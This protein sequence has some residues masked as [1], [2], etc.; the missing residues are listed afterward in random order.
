LNQQTPARRA[1][2]RLT[3]LGAAV[4]SCLAS[5]AFCLAPSANADVACY[6]DALTQRGFNE[7]VVNSPISQAG[8]TVTPTFTTPPEVDAALPP[9]AAGQVSRTVALVNGVFYVAD[10]ARAAGT[11]AETTNMYTVD[12]AT[13]A[14]TPFATVTDSLTVATGGLVTSV[15]S[16]SAPTTTTTSTV[17]SGPCSGCDVSHAALDAVELAVCN[18][19][20]GVAGLIFGNFVH[21]QCGVANCS[22]GS[23]PG[24][25]GG[26]VLPELLFLHDERARLHAAE[27]VDHVGLQHDLLAV[28]A[29]NGSHP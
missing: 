1:L 28:S 3:T 6:L 20:C 16:P 17:V 29:G 7:V 19:P 18:L 25:G 12:R 13:G 22:D 11:C 15:S 23:M 14:T 2:W 9:V 27:P 4:V 21:L 10:R 26:V 24:T 8:V 5:T